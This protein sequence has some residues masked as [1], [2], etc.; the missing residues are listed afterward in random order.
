MRNIIV[1][2][3]ICVS[4]VLAANT[5]TAQDIPVK[6]SGSIIGLADKS[7]VYLTD[8][9]KPEDTLART[10]SKKDKFELSGKMASAKLY[11]LSF[12]PSGKKALVFLDEVPIVL[13]GNI[14]AVQDFATSGST[15]H[16]S[17]RDFQKSFD[18]LFK[19][20]AQLTETANRSGV[21]DSLMKVYRQ[22]TATIADSADQFATTHRDQY[23][24]PFMWATL[25]QVVDDP[26]RIEK[27]F[28]S[29]TPA[30][31]NSFYGKFLADRIADSKIG[32]VGSPALD[33]T[34]ADT[35]GR[36]IALSSFRGKYVLIDFWASWCGPCRQE[37]PNVVAAYEKF[38]A[39][40]F[41]V[42]GVSLDNNRDR[43]L[44][45]ISDD[46]LAW[47]QVSDLKYWQN[48]VAL[49]YRIQSI[50][51]NLLIDPNGI[52]VGKNLRGEELQSKLCDLLGCN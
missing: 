35:S 19:K 7:K 17:F 23:V 21:N 2:I 45:A 46:R 48:E 16:A 13:R 33:F 39:K 44:K 9:D 14:N 43:W 29:F 15:A 41:T 10:V 30:V 47:T 11:N 31:Q 3:S 12:M 36:A 4:T 34:Q 52:I 24:A 8:P 51:Q 6:I 20:L 42:L 5:V 22:L 50:P 1:G 32:R 28:N 26:A 38:R 18:P 40:N 27:S 49:Q 37:N 25:L